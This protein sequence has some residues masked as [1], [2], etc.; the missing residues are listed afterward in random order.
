MDDHH[1]LTGFRR[2]VL[3]EL[4]YAEAQLLALAQAVPAEDFGWSPA[5]H[6]RSFAAVLVHVAA[7][8]LMLLDRAGARHPEVVDFYSGMAADPLARLCAMIRKNCALEKTLTA[9]AAVIDLLKRS[10]AAVNECWTTAAEE[11]L[12]STENFF[13]EIET[14]RRLYLRMLAHSH[15]HMGQLIAYVRAMGYQ[16]PWPDPVSKL[17]EVEASLAGR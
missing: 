6:A 14:R 8:N 11:E 4:E 17:E 5:E 15:E 3:N 9:K 1:H 13:G 10:F 16:V 12:W 7:G 2:E